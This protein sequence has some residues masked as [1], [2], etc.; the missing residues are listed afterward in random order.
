MS[1]V[2]ENHEVALHYT[3]YTGVDWDILIFMN[4]VCTL[5]SRHLTPEENLWLY[6][7]K[8]CLPHMIPPCKWK[9]RSLFTVCLC[10]STIMLGK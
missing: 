10:G 8:R 1:P 7:V 3:S 2:Q 4:G 5:Q 6:A 9:R